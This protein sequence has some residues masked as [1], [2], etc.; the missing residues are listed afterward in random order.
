MVD[1]YTLQEH[2]CDLWKTP[3]GLICM[4]HI[5]DL[6]TSLLKGVGVT[7]G[8]VISSS[9]SSSRELKSASTSSEFASDS[10]SGLSLEPLAARA[11]SLA[12]SVR[13]LSTARSEG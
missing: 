10:A 9:S 7:S 4:R 8:P 13:G 3:T 1:I 6:G 12:A 5:W 11:A 2:E